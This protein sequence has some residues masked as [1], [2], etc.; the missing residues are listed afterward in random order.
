M[1]SLIRPPIVTVLGHVDHGKTTLLDAIRKTDVASR[2]AGGITQSIGASLIETADRKKIT[3]IDT[4]GHSA[5]SKMRSRG[6]KVAD[7]VLLVVSADD[8]VK[9][10]TVESL[11][12]I[13]EANV[14]FIVVITKIDLS[15]SSPETVVGELEKEGVTFEGRG[16]DT[17]K[18]EVSAKTGVG[19]SHLLEIISLLSEVHGIKGDP[20]AP[21]EAVVIETVKDRRGCVA[22]IV[23]RNGTLKVGDFIGGEEVSCKVRGLFDYTGKPV[24]EIFPGE[25]GQIIGFEGMPQVGTPLSIGPVKAQEVK[26][27]Q[28]KVGK[29]EKDEIPIFLKAATLG[30][31]EALVAS[32]P[33]KIV[34]IAKS[35]GNLTESDILNAKALGALIFV[36]ESKVASTVTKLAESEG[37]KV[38]RFE[39]IYELIERLEELIKKGKTDVLGKAEV[40]ASFPY[41]HK[42]VAGCK[43]IEGKIAKTNTIIVKRG[44]KELAK[45]KIISMRKQK[46]EISEAKAGEEFG[47]IF[48]PQIDFAVGDMLISVAK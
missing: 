48:D 37:V 6:V 44:E 11:Q 28:E 20:S 23:V 32:F 4:P 8:G 35:V 16:G 5:F 18:I 29:L 31:L 22:T 2:E 45:V 12:I 40:L 34:V 9:P 30:S 19:I 15:S 26:E 13:R 14:P 39:V 7:I 47:V 17:P 21:L 38:E 33:P 25:P 36:F 43:V 10:Q 1:G 27:K 24:K 41:E 42:K 3:F 46:Q